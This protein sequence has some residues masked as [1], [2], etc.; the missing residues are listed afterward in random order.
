MP[1]PSLK[2]IPIDDGELY[3]DRHFLSPKD[4]EGLFQQLLKQLNWQTESYTLFGKTVTAPR[5]LQ[6][7]GDTQAIYTYSGIVHHPLPWPP[8]LLTLKRRIET[9]CTCSFNGVLANLY[10]DGRDS[11]GWHRDLEPELGPTPN[12][13]S[14]SLGAERNFKLK[15]DVSKQTHSLLLN[16]GSLLLMSGVLQQHWKH[17]LPKTQRATG[18]RI[19]LTFRLILP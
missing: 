4:S 17:A 9:H 12:I 11:M 15:H 10:R 19:N 14:L 2:P 5:L 1:A 8:L 16:S 7:Y 6:W 13:A 3:L 18:E